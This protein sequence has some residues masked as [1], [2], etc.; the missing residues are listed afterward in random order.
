MSRYG[1]SPQ[2]HDD[3]DFPDFSDFVEEPSEL[4]SDESEFFGSESDKEELLEDLIRR[5]RFEKRKQV[6]KINQLT[7]SKRRNY[8]Y[9]SVE[10]LV[11]NTTQAEVCL[12]VEQLTYIVVSQS[13]AEGKLTQ[14]SSDKAKNDLLLCTETMLLAALFGTSDVIKKIA[15]LSNKMSQELRFPES[16]IDC[17]KVLFEKY[18]RRTYALDNKGYSSTWFHFAASLKSTL[19]FTPSAT[20][21]LHFIFKQTDNEITGIHFDY[22]NL[23]LLF[24]GKLLFDFDSTILC[25]TVDMNRDK[26]GILSRHRQS[27]KIRQYCENHIKGQQQ[28]IAAVTE[29]VSS[30]FATAN[31]GL[32]GIATF[33]GAPGSGK[34]A[35]AE[36]LADG[37]NEVYAASYRKL[38]L[39][40]EM[41]SDERAGLKLFGS[42]SQYIDSALG[43]LTSE[44]F[45][46]PRTVIILDEIEKAHRTVIQSLLT[47]LEKGRITDQTSNKV[48]DFSQCFVIFTTNL[49]HKA[50][51]SISQDKQ[52]D[53]KS[54][55][56]E[57]SGTPGLSPELISRLS[58]GYVALF[59]ELDASDL[60]YV[61]EHA[62]KIA[63]ADN[64]ISWP[65]NM[66]E[67][68][69][70]TLGGN[71]EPRSVMAQTA[72][73]QS[74]IL[75]KVCSAEQDIGMAPRIVVDI[76]EDISELSFAVVTQEPQIKRLLKT[77]FKGCVVVSDL[78]QL[79][80]SYAKLGISTVLIHLPILTSGVTLNKAQNVR[81]YS[82]DVG[83]AFI[84][85]P[86]VKGI[87]Q[88]YELDDASVASFKQLIQ[89]AA[90]RSRLLAKVNEFR[91]R[92]M[93]VEFDFQLSYEAS[94]IRVTLQNPEYKQ[95][96]RPD[97]FEPPYMQAPCIPEISFK[98]LIGL[99]SLKK[100][101]GFILKTLRGDNDFV[102]DMPKGYLLA[103]LPGTGKSYFAKAVAGECK[104]PFIPVNAADLMLGNPVENI[105][106]LFDVAER[107]AP[108]IVFFD[109][110]DAIA[111]NR[112]ASSQIGRL[113]V[114]T[115]L[116][117]LDGFNNGQY[118]VFVL[119]ATNFAK[120]LDPAIMRHGR[121]DK[122]V[123][124]PLPDVQARAHYIQS[125]AD[126]Y[127]F[128]IPATTVQQFAR[129][130][131]GAP[132]GFIANLFRDV[133]L[134]IL[135]E[136][137][138]F[139]TDMLDEQLLT[140]TIGNKKAVS[141]INTK[142][143]LKV[144][145]HE[146]GHYLL[147]KRWFPTAR[148]TSL[149]IQE[150][151][152]AGGVTAF[153]YDEQDSTNT[154]A[155][156]K[157][158]LQILLAGRAAEKLL[159]KE[160]DDITTGA[161]HD[162]KQ[163]TE[164]ARIAISDCGFSDTLGLAD[165]KQLPMLQ[166]SVEQEVL[167]WLNEAYAQS[168][169]YLQQNWTLV[170]CIAEELFE[171]EKL[172]QDDLD[173]LLAKFDSRVVLSVK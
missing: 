58:R 121:F 54:L 110:F 32:K 50:A 35:L 147:N 20:D 55:L 51:K 1:T 116:T 93:A 74:Q 15:Q 18:D 160:K 154:K 170:K 84:V 152:S 3:S 46:A 159:S 89:Q 57:K 132:F 79:T 33:M 135:T 105:N 94:S 39:N 28:A 25:N 23:A 30:A 42:G 123:N 158:R 128:A 87:E 148:C 21:F 65:A 76:P 82:F 101:M 85:P 103:G 92:N 37:L 80:D 149:S 124:I 125:C 127:Q 167:T 11:L 112:Q 81:F 62:A 59:R 156:I 8:F 153:D 72:K 133:Q 113:A 45:V 86:A 118:P 139:S 88:A 77:H 144:A 38:V 119:A 53:L 75:N 122:V 173:Q 49:G 16:V 143:R 108:C 61:A 36:T 12:F 9:G 97:D 27:E 17:R 10:Q 31:S 60:L 171:R 145:Y 4:V 95:T 146:T 2:Q 130:I 13:M 22:S 115:L 134:N 117:R 161:S 29:M 43:D 48:V 56:A 66:A 19:K 7:T 70:E 44:I 131:S 164:L 157:A 69:I 169:A 114:N 83:P 126:K 111:L 102:L 47:L 166:A 142:T 168:E 107:Y 141:T 137:K 106:H 151:E 120:S 71:V 73:L 163:A 98:D 68:I 14:I 40:M 99:D 63:R 96:F 104:V 150:H 64:T 129:K 165:F 52:L 78:D 172:D 5:D 140:A 41:Y 26:P 109:E 91:K 138:P 24:Q 6:F 162:I 34:T 67:L 100:N 155:S 136:Q 90:K